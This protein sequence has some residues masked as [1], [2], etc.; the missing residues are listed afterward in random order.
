MSLVLV[1]R[2]D[3]SPLPGLRSCLGVASFERPSATPRC[4]SRCASPNASERPYGAATVHVSEP[5]AQTR[6]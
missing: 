2:S 4:G 3:G 6:A 5:L 1:G